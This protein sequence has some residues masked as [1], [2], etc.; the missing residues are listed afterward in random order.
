MGRCEGKLREPR[1]IENVC[2]LAFNHFG[3]RKTKNNSLKKINVMVKFIGALM[4]EFSFHYF[5]HL[6]ICL[7]AIHRLSLQLKVEIQD[8]FYLEMFFPQHIY[9]N[10]NQYVLSY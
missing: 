10:S 8:L 9:M 5:N 4:S 6:W 2:T 1:A 3:K 7:C